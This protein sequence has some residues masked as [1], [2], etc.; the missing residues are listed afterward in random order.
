MESWFHTL[1]TELVNQ[2][3]YRT[4]IQAKTDVFE[5]IEVFYNRSRRHSSLGYMTPA[6]YEMVKMAA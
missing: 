2:R 1:K 6:Q 4:R 3:K 5:Y